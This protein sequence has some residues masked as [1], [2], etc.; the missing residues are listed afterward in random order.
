MLG[1]NQSRD[2]G[3]CR[4]LASLGG[5]WCSSYAHGKVG[6]MAEEES[7]LESERFKEEL[8]SLWDLT[9][10]AQHGLKSKIYCSSFCELV[11]E[12]TGRWQVPLP[13]LQVLR[14]ALC[15]F[16]HS[17]ASFPCGCE[18]VQ[19]TLSS[20]ALSFFELLLFFGKDEFL[21]D[22]LKDILLSFQD[23][24][25]CLGRHKNV[26][27]QLVNQIVQDGGPW[28][29]PIL[30]VIL[31]ESI[32]SQDEVKQYLNSEDPVFFELRVRYLLACERIQEAVA[33]AKA[34]IEHLEARRHLYFHQVYLTCLW[35]ASLFDHLRK[36]MALIDGRDA[37]EILCNTEEE[38]KD[39]L[40]LAFSKEFLMQQ[41]Q[42][43]DMYCMWDLVFIWSKLHL[44]A[45]PSKQGFMEECHQMMLC[46][47]N[48]K[49]IF[50][51]MKIIFDEMGNKGLQF[52]VELCAHALQMDL[53][54]DPVTKSLI[55]KTIAF[56]LPNDLEVCRACA[57]LVF[58][59]ERTVESYKTVYLLYT[60]PDQEYHVDSS[61]IK[62]D[63]R[64]E[65]LQMLKKGLFFDPEFWNL[66]TLRTNCLKLMS[67]KVM[68]AALNEIMEE[69][70]WIPNYCMKEP[71]KFYSDCS[72]NQAD[73]H[74]GKDPNTSEAKCGSA[75][76]VVPEG[77]AAPP[78]KK[79]GRK[80]GTRFAKVAGTCQLRRS[81]RQLDMAQE[82]SNRLRGSR[83]QRHLARQVEKKTLKRRGRKPRW[84]LQDTA[85]QEENSNPRRMRRFGRKTQNFPTE[86]KLPERDT[87][88]E[89]EETNERCDET[90]VPC[91]AEAETETEDVESQEAASLTPSLPLTEELEITAVSGIMLE[92]SLPDNEIMDLFSVEDDIGLS[93]HGVLQYQE[94]DAGLQDI[95]LE[96]PFIKLYEKETDP[97]DESDKES[98][99]SALSPEINCKIYVESAIQICGTNIH[100]LHNYSKTYEDTTDFEPRP[101]EAVAQLEPPMQ[102]ESACE[103]KGSKQSPSRVQHTPSP[104][105]AAEELSLIRHAMKSHPDD[106]KV[107]EYAFSWR[108]G[109]CHFCKRVFLSLPH[110]KDHVKEHNHPLKHVCLHHDCK[111]RFKTQME[112]RSHM[113]SHEPFQA[114]CSFAGCHWRCSHLGQLFSHETSH[115]PTPRAKDTAVTRP[116]DDHGN[117]EGQG[118]EDAHDDSSFVWREKSDHKTYM[119]SGGGKL[120]ATVAA[121]SSDKQT[122]SAANVGMGPV[123]AESANCAESSLA[124]GQMVNGH[125]NDESD[126][127]MLTSSESASPQKS[128]DEPRHETKVHPTSSTPP[129]QSAGQ[130]HKAA[131]DAER[132]PY[133]GTS[134]KP[135]LRLSPSAYLDEK[136]IS[137]PKRRK[138]SAD[139]NPAPV[140]QSEPCAG[141]QRQRCT[142]CFCSFGS[143]EELQK[144]L[145][146]NKCMSLFDS[147]EEDAW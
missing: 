137:M 37:V 135:F 98:E 106:A 110:Y 114:E 32:Q 109:K 104:S 145:S 93:V 43:G 111:Q 40:L 21:E 10:S 8:E 112:L 82:N 41:L 130:G 141:T 103:I 88:Q 136:Y 121:L 46:A 49:S 55:Y 101:S 80:P 124:D 11:G 133:G 61:L 99:F 122:A 24:F 119:L 73:K 38:E 52:C 16:T 22:P 125:D 142:K 90:L 117:P 89:T 138:P 44:R 26:Y 113:R 31:K 81:F 35:K 2:R 45:N 108:K 84:L 67:E 30:Q 76:A 123:P 25:L 72:A 58:F 3:P 15:Y 17:T 51:F 69:D 134:N 74:N 77:N 36:E 57:L 102:Q 105:D 85:R 47:T 19:Y 34:C 54:H 131:R 92:V 128:E 132:P 70:K 62:N 68:K 147:D 86:T 4:K 71:Y 75:G 39:D 50:P 60:H 118:Q 9:R 53:H 144:H 65:I 78:A 116:S 13:Q 115:Y 79:R 91:L 97:A 5:W 143:T 96:Y 127:V 139:P 12:H 146:S 129:R 140:E 120:T 64:F 87:G 7:D 42:S 33:L 18:H 23:C 66:I 56:L 27:L 100:D 83:Q 29:N 94:D 6:S 63:T 48:V 107:Q 59:L 14:T 1:S 28:E 20:L 95:P 126:L